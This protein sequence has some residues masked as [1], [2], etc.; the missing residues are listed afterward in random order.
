MEWLR[1]WLLRRAAK[2]YARRLGPYL[3]RAY[4]AAER[5]TPAQIRAAAAKLGLNFRYIAL[6]Y[7]SFMSADDYD[8]AAKQTPISVPYDE[9]R[10]LIA[11]FRRTDRFA[12]ADHYESGLGMAGETGHGMDG[13]SP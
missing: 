5:Y 12:A 9:A 13:G 7:A 10:D 4:G 8:S 2:R 6:G 3:R 11:R 1:Q